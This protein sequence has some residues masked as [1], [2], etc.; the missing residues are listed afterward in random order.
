MNINHLKYFQD[1]AKFGSISKA[2]NINFVGQP[3]ISKAI[4]SLEEDL[5]TKLILH[6]R[7]RFELTDEGIIIYEKSQIV[8]DAVEKLKDSL[9]SKKSISGK[10]H[11]ACQ[12]SMAESF[13]LIN[14]IKV[15]LK[16]YPNIQ[17]ELSL[18]RTDLVKA[19]LNKGKIDF[20]LVLNN[21]DFK[22]F[23]RQSISSGNFYLIKSANYRRDWKMEGV[24]ITEK[25]KEVTRLKQL[26]LN[27]NNFNLKTKLTIGSWSAIKNFVMQDFGIGL[28]PDYLIQKELK[29][30]LLKIVEKSNYSIPYEILL[31][32]EKN[33]YL[34]SKTKTI[35][36][37]FIDL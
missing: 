27:K 9:I 21:R 20:A 8:F 33:K 36:D 26:F 24:L 5:D 10:I 22:E 16:K 11:F 4:R 12:S 3:A 32:T 29:S 2:A 6:N 25:T 18:G 19:W 35:I 31:I 37:Q 7:N 23:N 15:M 30:G 28:L 1:A 13:F 34:S 17:P 14:S